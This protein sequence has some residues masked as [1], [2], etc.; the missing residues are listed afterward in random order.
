MK[1]MS[2]FYESFSDKINKNQKISYINEPRPLPSEN[3]NLIIEQKEINF[4]IFLKENQLGD[5]K[6]RIPKSEPIDIPGMVTS[7][8]S[9]TI[10]Y[11]L[12]KEIY[13]MSSISS[14]SIHSV[15]IHSANT[16]LYV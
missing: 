16:P 8:P 11:I 7:K 13:D 6:Q 2:K 12:L 3:I 4:E 10:S 1:K 9:K 15:S 5:Y 14:V